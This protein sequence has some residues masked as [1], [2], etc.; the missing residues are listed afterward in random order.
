[1]ARKQTD[2]EWIAEASRILDEVDAM[3]PNDPALAPWQTENWRRKGEGMLAGLKP[4]VG[5]RIR[6]KGDK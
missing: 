3:D 5:D 1:M 6:K 2:A 4:V